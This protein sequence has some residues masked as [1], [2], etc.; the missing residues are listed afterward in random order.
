MNMTQLLGAQTWHIAFDFSL[1]TK[2]GQVFKLEMK[3][4]LNLGLKL[5]LVLN[6]KLTCA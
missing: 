6:S 1:C 3:T 4:E 2:A 5:S